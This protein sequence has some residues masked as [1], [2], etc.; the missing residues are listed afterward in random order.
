MLTDSNRAIPFE[1]TVQ[2]LYPAT[3]A[4]RSAY[5]VVDAIDD[6]QRQ[7]G[8]YRALAQLTA[9]NGAD[10]PE[11]LEQLQRGDLAVLLAVLNANTEA[12]C[13]RAREAAVSSAK[14]NAP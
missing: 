13:A 2:A 7:L 5:A 9:I 14:G 12:V 8:A 1:Q 3:E 10:S 6:L 4:A 11:R